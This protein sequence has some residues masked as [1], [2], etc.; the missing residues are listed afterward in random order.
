MLHER[1]LVQKIEIEEAAGELSAVTRELMRDWYSRACAVARPEINT[2]NASKPIDWIRVVTEHPANEHA[3][4]NFLARYGNDTLYS[5]FLDEESRMPAFIPLL[6]AVRKTYQ[7]DQRIAG[8]VDRN[9]QDELVPVPH[10]ELFD[11]IHL[12][13][14]IRSP[15]RTAKVD[16]D[17]LANTNLLFYYGKYLDQS[18][19]A[20]ALL[21]TEILVPWRVNKLKEGCSRLGYSAFEMEFFDVHSSCDDGHAR[22]WLSNVIIPICL[23]SPSIRES[24]IHG[25][26]IRL[27]TSWSYLEFKMIY[28]TEVIRGQNGGKGAFL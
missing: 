25:I 22:D 8:A 12:A 3:W 26:G 4:Y 24:V 2:L 17:H 19:L 9:L 15:I 18:L 21:A 6:Q 11:R 7:D 10:Y 1:E 20:G 13:A 27:A 5:S 14:S 16:S 23:K 28:A